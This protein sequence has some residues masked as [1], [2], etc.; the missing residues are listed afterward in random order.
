MKLIE[1]IKKIH[2]IPENTFI[3][4][5]RPW[6]RDAESKLVPFPDDLQ[7]PQSVLAEGFEYFLEVSTAREILEDF[8]EKKRSLEQ[9]TDFVIYYA[10]N[11]AFPEWAYT[12]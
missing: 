10:E 7:I 2:E 4:A 6:N 9:V 1:I 11:D 8:L 3:Y 12:L 5:R